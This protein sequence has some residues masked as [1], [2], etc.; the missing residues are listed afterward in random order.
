MPLDPE[1]QAVLQQMEEAGAPPLDEITPGMA[2]EAFA[3]MVA[4]QGEPEAVA[5][6]DNREVPGPAGS[7]PIR[8]YH[9]AAAASPGPALFYIHGGGWVIMD[10]ESHDP[11]CRALANGLGCR[12]VAVHY[13]RAPEDPFP[14]AV[15]D[16]FA[17]LRWIADHGAEIGVDPT[18]I[19]VAGDSAGGNLSAAM[20][21]LARDQGGPVI[22]AQVLHCPVTNHAF[23]TPSY[24]ENA[25]GYFLTAELMHWFWGHYVS[26]DADGRNPLASP[27]QAADHSGLPPALIQTAE[28]DPLRDEG[29]AYAERLRRA[30]VPA[31][32]TLYPGVVHDQWLMMGVVP[33]GRAA[34]DEAVSFLRGH[35]G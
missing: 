32:Y 8:V 20:T 13:R 1:V 21:L 10:L 6:V 5:D 2:R 31:E 14:A 30:G 26:D 16:C 12:V 4:L 25:D 9:P 34:L 7:I 24:K 22:R 17:V 3:G 27:L 33:K 18:R 19:A 11:I 15:D 28:Y 23:E 35:L 29:E